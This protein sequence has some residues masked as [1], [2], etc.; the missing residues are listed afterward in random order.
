MLGLKSIKVLKIFDK[1]VLLLKRSSKVQCVLKSTNTPTPTSN[2]LERLHISSIAT[3][4]LTQ[5]ESFVSV[6]H[7]FYINAF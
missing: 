7:N 1:S 4:N 2:P 6:L 3:A 5:Y